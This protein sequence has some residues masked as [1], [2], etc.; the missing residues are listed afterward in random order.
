MLMQAQAGRTASVK[1]RDEG[2]AYWIL[3]E[4]SVFKMTS[5][6]TGGLFAMAEE[7]ILPGGGPPPHIHHAE[8]EYFYLLEGVLTFFVGG[9]T[10]QAPA[11]T[12]VRAPR[13]IV[14]SFRNETATP[15]KFLVVVSP[16]GF[17]NFFRRV[18]VP[19]VEGAP[20]PPV[21]E[22]AIGRIVDHA[23]EFQL[24]VVPG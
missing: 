19:V 7:T 5:A 17:E 21:T 4:K 12:T 18:G 16:G 1:A 6:E 22:E 11:G 14:H 24:E 13:G 20:A 3:N 10:F 2:E 23:A 15:V 8:D 9:E